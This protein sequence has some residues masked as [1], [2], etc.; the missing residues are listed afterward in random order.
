MRR[1]AW[2]LLAITWGCSSPFA[3]FRDRGG[4]NNDYLIEELRSEIAEVRHSLHA[5]EVEL[6]L[7]EEKLETDQVTKKSGFEEELLL[8]RT[9]LAS[10]E[11][12]QERFNADL[13]SLSSHANQTTSSLTV[14]R[15]RILQLEE[16]KKGRLKTYTVQKGDTLD[17]IAR[18]HQIP[19]S[20]LK[21]LNNLSS[22][23]ILIGQE[24]KVGSNAP[25][26]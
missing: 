11:R 23:R 9:K 12:L 19:L 8:I 15:D 2:L 17:K 21:D 24:L 26:R 22:D 13:S 16:I 6:R 20:A 5:T 18:M 25:L 14:Y 10:L 4:S 3:A 7:L 1:Y